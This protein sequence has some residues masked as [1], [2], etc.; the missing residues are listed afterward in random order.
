[1]AGEGSNEAALFGITLA[2]FLRQT[3]AQAQRKSVSSAMCEFADHCKLRVQR[4][5]AMWAAAA[6]TWRWGEGPV[7]L[8]SRHRAKPEL[9]QEPTIE[10][11]AG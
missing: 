7:R 4:M 9:R 10:A 3:L 8:L 2:K 6:A 11:E 5:L 1:M